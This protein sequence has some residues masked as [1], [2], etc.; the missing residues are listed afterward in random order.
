MLWVRG[1]GVSGVCGG[2]GGRVL[3]GGVGL[4]LW[5][6]ELPDLE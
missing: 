6:K 3:V 4:G 5:R 2:R 1:V